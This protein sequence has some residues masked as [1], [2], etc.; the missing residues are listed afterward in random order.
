MRVVLKHAVR[1]RPHPTQLGVTG[2]AKLAVG[3]V[4]RENKERRRRLA[5]PS[6]EIRNMAS[7]AVEVP[8]R[9]QPSWIVSPRV[10]LL[11]FTLGG[12]AVAYAFWALW[13]FAHA[14]LLLLVAIWAIV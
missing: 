13:R 11:W 12:A 5:G 8:V 7:T 6:E 9:T 14:P 2:R 1:A 4:F 3:G 10:D